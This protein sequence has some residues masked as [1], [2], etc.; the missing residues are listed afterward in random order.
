VQKLSVAALLIIASLWTVDARSQT[1]TQIDVPNSTSTTALGINGKGDIVGH[2][3]D[4]S[5]NEHGFLDSAGTFTKIDD[6]GATNTYPYGVNDSGQIVGLLGGSSSSSF[7]Y[8]GGTFAE[9][10]RPV[11]GVNN[12][13]VAVGNDNVTSSYLYIAANSFSV[14][15]YLPRRQDFEGRPTARAA[16]LILSALQTRTS[17]YR[18]IGSKP[19]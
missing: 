17:R 2:Y 16:V 9:I 6:P 12:N 19:A 13:G 8:S 11:Y 4:S 3:T 10:N 14:L 5:G 7:V 15:S 1:F 18:R